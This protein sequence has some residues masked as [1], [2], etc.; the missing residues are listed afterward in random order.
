[1]SYTFAQLFQVKVTS[2]AYV[3][4]TIADLLTASANA[5]T[6]QYP[7]NEKKGEALVKSVVKTGS[8]L[9]APL[10]AGLN[11]TDHIVSG[12]HRTWAANRICSLYGVN[13]KGVVVL[14]TDTVTL[15]AIEPVVLIDYCEV[16]DAATLAALILAENGS[17]TM[18]GPET[19]AVKASGGYATPGDRFKLRFSPILDNNLTICDSLGMPI[20][21]SAITLGQ[22]AGKFLSTVKTLASATDNQLEQVASNFNEYLNGDDIEL[23]TKFA[24]YYA[25]FLTEFLS[26]VVDLV[27]D[28]GESVETLDK[29]GDVIELTYA[30]H[31]RNSIVV[32]AKV[33]KAPSASKVTAELMDEMK[34]LLLAHN[35][36]VPVRA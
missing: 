7:I 25:S 19:A 3:E 12:R 5:S 8:L 33:A 9:I 20:K 11:G 18:S 30:D 2:E 6:A 22:M 26:D 35:I 17:R 23:P 34:A 4:A 31:L 16:T 14:K 27:D 10:M 21:V 29:N 15:E 28:D 24:Q 13:A 1:M 32:E 36:T